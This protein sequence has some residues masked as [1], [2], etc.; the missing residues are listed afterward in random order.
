MY[1]CVRGIVS[2]QKSERSCKCVLGVLYQAR[3]VSRHVGVCKGYCTRP[4]QSAVM[5]VCIREI[6]PSQ[7]SER[8]CKCALGVLY[9][10]RTVSVHVSVC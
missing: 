5:Y 1:V 3:T 2:S 6:V 7:N 10:A 4:E 9:Q 8:S